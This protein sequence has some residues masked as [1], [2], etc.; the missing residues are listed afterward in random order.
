[1]NQDFQLAVPVRGD[2]RV[3][4]KDA[5]TLEVI[6]RFEI[7]NTITYL[8]L[9]ALAR[10]I[11]QNTYTLTDYKV[12]TLRLGTGTT[13]PAKTDVALD[14]QVFSIALTDGMRLVTTTGPYELKI[15]TTLGSGDANGNTLT[16]AGVFLT[17]GD[18]FCRQIHPAVPKTGALVVD[19]DWRISFTA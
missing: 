11:A 4:V 17:N 5:V 3:I 15:L 6:R 10:L 2:M 13:P 18:L 7:R 8:A 19:Y 12:T 16:E 14:T 9:G 1:M